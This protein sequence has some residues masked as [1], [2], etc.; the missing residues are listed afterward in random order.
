[1][2]KD[3]GASWAKMTATEARKVDWRDL[4][5]DRPHEGVVYPQG[6]DKIELIARVRAALS[7]VRIALHVWDYSAKLTSRA[8]FLP[9]FSLRRRASYRPSGPARRLPSTIRARPRPRLLQSWRP[10]LRGSLHQ[11]GVSLRVVPWG[12]WPSATKNIQFASSHWKPAINHHFRSLSG[13][14]WQIATILT[15][16]HGGLSFPAH[17]IRACQG[18][19]FSN[20]DTTQRQEWCDET[21]GGYGRPRNMSIWVIHH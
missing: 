21:W 12:I 7:K 3:G 13:A 10:W 20:C 6:E 15:A 1:M 16:K 2:T 8:A 11:R 9:P 17:Q 18:S 5:D 14:R 4:P 19:L